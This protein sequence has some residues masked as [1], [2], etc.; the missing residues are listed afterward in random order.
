ML[1]SSSFFLTLFIFLAAVERPS[2][3]V[4]VQSS[5]SVGL[6]VGIVLIILI[7]PI[8]IAAIYFVW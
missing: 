1:C 8:I 3:P 6:I 4:V 7:L 5:P 2:K